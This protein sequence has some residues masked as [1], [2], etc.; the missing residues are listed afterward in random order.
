[1]D[2]NFEGWMENPLEKSISTEKFWQRFQN[3]KIPLSS[4]HKSVWISP[5]G[6][7]VQDS[8]GGWLEG[9]VSRDGGKRSG[10]P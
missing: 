9:G 10:E 4:V 6:A 1:M 7:L 2:I 5:A 3:K 8:R